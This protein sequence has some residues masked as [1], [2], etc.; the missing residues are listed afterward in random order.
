MK[1]VFK[2]AALATVLAVSCGANAYQIDGDV[3]VSHTNSHDGYD[4][5]TA[6]GLAATYYFQNVQPVRSAPLAE[7]AFLNRASNVGIGYSTLTGSN[8]GDYNNFVLGGEYYVPNSQF[9]V[10]GSYIN[11]K[12]AGIKS[13]G[14][15]AKLGYLPMNGLL[16]TLGA[17][18]A[19][20]DNNDTQ[21]TL[22]GKYVFPVAG[23]GSNFVNVEGQVTLADNSPFKV[24]A[25]YYLDP[26]LGVGLGYAGSTNSDVKGTT[27]IHAQKFINPMMAIG[28][29][30]SSTDGNTAFGVNLK[31]RF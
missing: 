6:L 3:T 9:Y 20:T 7:A 27:D 1:N 12:Y 5:S 16:L 8:S 26:T 2:I 17:T 21:A 28:G 23:N 4:A 22:G 15:D 19:G 18:S 11:S 10:A 14:F 13:D 25:D 29:Q 24:K 30:V 31:G